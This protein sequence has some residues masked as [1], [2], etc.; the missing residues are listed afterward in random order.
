MA[1]ID[2]GTKRIGVAITDRDQMLASPYENYDVRGPEKDA[3]WFR[4]FVEREQVTL[5]VVGL[6]VHVSGDESQK[7]IEARKFGDWLS[8][9][10]DRPVEMQ[11]MQDLYHCR[12]QQDQVTLVEQV[13]LK[14]LSMEI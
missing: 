2:Y 13:I 9:V 7:S 3:V 14:H 12:L 4:E 8:G 10:T 5:F 6:P 1:G 11:Q